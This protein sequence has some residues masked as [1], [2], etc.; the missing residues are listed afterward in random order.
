M[1][2]KYGV[3][4][5]ELVDKVF[6]GHGSLGNDHD[7]SP[8]QEFYNTE[9]PQREF[10]ADKAKYHLK[11][12]GYGDAKLELLA[13]NAA[14]EGATDSAQLIQGSLGS[15]GLDVTVKNLPND[16]FWA[17]V[18]N[19]QGKGWVTSTWAGR[20]TNDWMFS[21]C[22]VE[23]SSWND[24]AWKGTPAADRFNELVIAARGELD[25]EKRKAMY[26]ECQKLHNEDGG[27]VVW[28]FANLVHGLNK[29]V[30]HPDV[31]ASNWAMDGAKSS[32][33]WWFS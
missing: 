21:A 10:D 3:K 14:F 8:T 4:R 13:S 7:I 5:Q 29:R 25:Y 18:W 33:R 30:S 32:E 22:C 20:P 2:I 19:K 12:S 9:L 1:A 15:I 6:R 27:A 16:G 17:N 28:G 11:K 31:I 26:W 23:G 24:T